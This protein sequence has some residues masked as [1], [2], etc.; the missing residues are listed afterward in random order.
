MILQVNLHISGVCDTGLVLFS[1]LSQTNDVQSLSMP[2]SSSLFSA[3]RAVVRILC[4]IYA[5]CPCL[6]CARGK[7]SEIACRVSMH[8]VHDF[9]LL[10]LAA[11]YEVGGQQGISKQRACRF[12]FLMQGKEIW[13]SSVILMRIF[14]APLSP[15]CSSVPSLLLFQR[16]HD[17][18]Q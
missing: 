11:P 18:L 12:C 5:C 3:L 15:F 4:M 17:F 8:F 13:C 1:N 10:S 6:V 16:Q 2:L 14:S 7:G 9:S